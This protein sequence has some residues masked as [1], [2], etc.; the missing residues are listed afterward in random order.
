M[1]KFIKKLFVY[2]EPSKTDMEMGFELLEDPA[3]SSSWGKKQD[4]RNNQKKE[5]KEQAK[6]GEQEEGDPA[7]S[8]NRPREVT[9]RYKKVSRKSWG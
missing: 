9:R 3:E 8:R 4:N 6:S 2:E 7:E 5:N 1:L